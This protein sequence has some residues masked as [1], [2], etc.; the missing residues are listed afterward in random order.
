WGTLRAF[1]SYNYLR[2]ENIDD[3]LVRFIPRVESATDAYSYSSVMLEYATTM[4]DAQAKMSSPTIVQHL[5]AAAAPFATRWVE[6][7]AVVTQVAADDA[8]RA[9]GLLVGDEITAADGYPMAAYANEHRKYGPASNEWTGY[10]NTT[11]L[12]PRGIPGGGIFKVRDANNRERT[13]TIQRD[14]SYLN[15][16]SESA[17]ASTNVFRE[18]TGRIGY[19]DIDRATTEQVDSAF[20]VLGTSRALILDARGRGSPNAS[21]TMT[22]AMRAVIHRVAALPNAVIDKQTIRMASEPC[23][24]TESRLPS[25]ACVLERRQFD[26]IMS[27]DTAGRFKGRVVVLIDERTQGAMEQFGLAIEGVANPVFIG[28][29]SAGAAGALTSMKLPGFITLTFSASELRHADGRQVQRVGLTPQ[30]DVVATVKGV[31]AGTDEVL[32]RAQTWLLQ[33]L[34]P[35]GPRRKQ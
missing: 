29:P 28:S 11:Q 30:V 17:R 26:D 35:A 5:G 32:A 27:A 7:R 34:D 6:G 13:A 1:H 33:Q 18:F 12:I 21:A 24:P 15:R 31:R 10:R 9:T 25:A 23:A 20:Q 3:A 16:F 4:N 22:P 8:G 14:A 2:D 19:I